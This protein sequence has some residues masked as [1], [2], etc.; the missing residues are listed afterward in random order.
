MKEFISIWLLLLGILLFPHLA[1]ALLKV[2][3]YQDG[4]LVSEEVVIPPGASEYKLELPYDVSV[5][6]LRMTSEGFYVDSVSFTNLYLSDDEVPAI[7]ELKDEI[8]KLEEEKEKLL[9]KKK[10]SDASFEILRG[11]MDKVQIDNPSDAHAWISLVEDRTEKHFSEVKDLDKKIGELDKKI[12]LLKQ[13]LKEID[14]PASRRKIVA[15]LKLSGNTKGGKLF[16]SYYSPRAGWF[17]TYKFV[18]RPS[19]K[20]LVVETY[21]NLWQKTGRDWEEAHVTLASIREGVSLSPPEERSLL[22]DISEKEAFKGERVDKLMF[23]MAPPQL[24]EK[25]VSFKETEL[26]VKIDLKQVT[27]LPSTGEKRRVLVWKGELPI[28]EIFYLCRPYL[29]TSV[30]RMASFRLVSPFDFLPGE[31]EFWVGETFLGSEE[32]EGMSRNGLYKIS[33]GSDERIEVERKATK[34]GETAKG[35]I[36]KSSVREYAYEIGVKNLTGEEIDLLLEDV[37]PVS[38]DSRIRV[39]LGR[40]TPKEAEQTGMGQIRWRLKLSPGEE[41]KVTFSYKIIYPQEEN[42]EL[43]WR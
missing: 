24:E 29:D 30:Y 35:I 36:D 32:I 43:K 1:H 38:M 13:R 26:G 23:S 31:S 3:L 4:V 9:L 39:E 28:D 5:K 15:Y 20:K 42:I 37:F 34:L 12:A 17:P 14:T 41:K 16:Y 19:E 25:G 7:K 6:S 2:E 18:L 40:I 10:I 22:V 33:F 8:R 11:L 21:A 27:S